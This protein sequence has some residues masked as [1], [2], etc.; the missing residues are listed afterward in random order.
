MPPTTDTDKLIEAI[1]NVTT[2]RGTAIGSAILTSI[3]GIA[4]IDPTVAPTGIDPES[5]KRSG[6]AAEV[7]GC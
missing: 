5:A 7:I 4:A 1:N 3:D 6:Y 2:A